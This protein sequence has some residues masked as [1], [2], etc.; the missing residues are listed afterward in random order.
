[1]MMFQSVWASL[2]PIIFTMPMT[3]VSMPRLVVMR[4]GH[5]YWFRPYMKRMTKRARDAGLKVISVLLDSFGSMR[6]AVPMDRVVDLTRQLLGQGAHAIK[7]ADVGLAN[8]VTS[9]RLFSGL[10]ERFPGAEFITHFHDSRGM[11]EGFF[12]AELNQFVTDSKGAFPHSNS[13]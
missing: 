6:E 3:M 12:V 10:R 4:S 7:L 8:P 11:I 13:H 2:V 1:M 5:R 9:Y